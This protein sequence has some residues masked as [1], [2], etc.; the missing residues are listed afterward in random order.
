METRIKWQ[1]GEGYITATYTGSGNGSASIASDVNEGID[2][3]Q[4]VTVATTQGSEPKSASIEVTQIG[5]RQRL[6]TSDGFVFC[7]ADGGRFAVLKDGGVTPDEPDVPVEPDAPEPEP[8]PSVPMGVSIATSDGQ[9]IATN[10]WG[11]QGTAVGVCVKTDAFAII[12]DL[13]IA[14]KRWYS[15]GSNITNVPAFTSQNSLGSYND[16]QAYTDL[17]YARSSSTN[18][19]AGYAKSRKIIISGIEYVGYVGSTGEWQ[20]IMAYDDDIMAAFTKLG[21]SFSGSTQ[22]RNI[23]TSCQYNNLNAWKFSF[24]SSG[25]GSFGSTSKTSSAYVKALYKYE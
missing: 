21:L 9:F 5:L 14:S 4:A 11:S 12:L 23:W 17:M 25:F 24:T 8:E 22:S 7:V 19:V 2:R 20:A 3:V 1:E 15:S 18:Y 13:E 6:I 10:F 16:G